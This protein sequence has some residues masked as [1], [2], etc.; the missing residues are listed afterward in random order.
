MSCSRNE[1]LLAYPLRV[2][3]SC[4]PAFALSRFLF[5][6]SRLRAI[7]NACEPSAMN[8]VEASLLQRQALNATGIEESQHLFSG[9]FVGVRGEYPARAPALDVSGHIRWLL[10]PF[11]DQGNAFAY[12]EPDVS[13]FGIAFHHIVKWFRHIFSPIPYTCR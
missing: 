6:P 4:L 7:V 9:R 5:G 1:H 8:E 13:P 10:V 3:R 12:K 11:A 2:A